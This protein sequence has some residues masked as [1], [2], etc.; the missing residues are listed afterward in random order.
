MP[1]PHIISRRRPCIACIKS[2]TIIYAAQGSFTIDNESVTAVPTTN[3]LVQFLSRIR[4]H[5]RANWLGQAKLCISH[6]PR[7]INRLWI[8]PL[9]SRHEDLSAV[10]THVPSYLVDFQEVYNKWT[11]AH[12]NMKKSL[13]L[14][15][16]KTHLVVPGCGRGT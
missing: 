5:S 14:V 12:T 2:T 7:P 8:F 9:G 13:P 1:L 6:S 4:G 3:L 11:S 15:V 16:I 10:A